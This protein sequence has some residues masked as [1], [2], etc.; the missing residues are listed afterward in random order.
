MQ[1]LCEHCRCVLLIYEQTVGDL[2]GSASFSTAGECQSYE[3]AQA[4]A[5]PPGSEA[6]MLLIA[7]FAVSGCDPLVAS[8]FP[9]SMRVSG[10][11]LCHVMRSLVVL[12]AEAALPM[13][14][15]LPVCKTELHSAILK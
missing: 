14:F 3:C 15:G 2:P 10:T 6:R 1:A 13:C 7:A 4:A 9:S 8:S 12:Q 11:V 5:E